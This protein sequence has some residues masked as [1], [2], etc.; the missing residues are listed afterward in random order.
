MSA[1][2]ELSRYEKTGKRRIKKINQKPALMSFLPAKPSK[3]T[4]E[5]MVEKV[6]EVRVKSATQKR[7]DR[8]LKCAAKHM[9]DF[10]SIV[11]E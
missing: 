5:K 1:L 7:R 2:P 8:R 10:R 6:P 4:I 11:R 3:K 9:P